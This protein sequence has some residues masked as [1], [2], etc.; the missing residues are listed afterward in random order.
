MQSRGELRANRRRSV[1]YPSR[2]RTNPTFPGLHQHKRRAPARS[3]RRLGANTRSKPVDIDAGRKCP[4]VEHDLAWGNPLELVVRDR[5]SGDSDEVS[6]A[7]CVDVGAEPGAGE[8]EPPSDGE[9]GVAGIV[10]CDRHVHKLEQRHIQRNMCPS[11]GIRYLPARAQRCASACPSCWGSRSALSCAREQL[12]SRD[13]RG[14]GRD[15]GPLS[16]QALPPREGRPA[17]SGGEVASRDRR[18]P[19]R[20]RRNRGPAPAGGRVSTAGM[21]GDGL[22]GHGVAWTGV[23]GRAA[24]GTAWR[25]PVRLGKAGK[26]R[27]GRFRCGSAGHAWARQAG[28][29]WAWRGQARRGSAGTACNTVF[30]ALARMKK[31]RWANT[32]PNDQREQSS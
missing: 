28:T 27:L 7:C 24:R 19:L 12:G 18:L 17:S 16:L 20:A 13:N 10:G 3:R 11:P 31:A 6:E 4:R 26:A 2:Y 21:A 5:V 22:V 23:A 25:G 8:P 32:G 9:V 1:P 30:R 15:L 14:S 29:G